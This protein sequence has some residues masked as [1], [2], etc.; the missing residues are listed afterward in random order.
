MRGAGRLL[1]VK[2]GFHKEEMLWINASKVKQR[3]RAGSMCRGSSPCK[4][5]REIG[6]MVSLQCC[7]LELSC[8]VN[9]IDDDDD[10]N[11]HVPK[12]NPHS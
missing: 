3:R 4:D 12:I 9:Q 8:F 10:S 7:C 2:G 1:G 6:H 5:P 11:Q